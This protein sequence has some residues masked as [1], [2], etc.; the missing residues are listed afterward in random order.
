MSKIQYRVDELRVD[1]K[2]KLVISGW[3]V[4]DEDYTL[5]VIINENEIRDLEVNNSERPDV[6][7][8]IKDAPLQCGFQNI[9]PIEDVELENVK[10]QL[11]YKEEVKIIEEKHKEELFL[12]EILY[13][14]DQVH[15]IRNK[16]Y[17]S[18]WVF[19]RNENPIEIKC[20][21]IEDLEVKRVQRPDVKKCYSELQDLY[22]GFIIR[23]NLKAKKIELSFSTDNSKITYKI[24]VL[25]HKYEKLKKLM[26]LVSLTSITKALRVLFTKGPKEF[27]RKLRRKFIRADE[28][29][30]DYMDWY[31]GKAPTLN[32]LQLQTKAKF[33]YMPKVSIIVPTYNTPIK[34]LEEMIES[35]IS[36][37]YTNWEL[38]IADGSDRK[39]APKVKE[40]LEAYKE[41]DSRIK[42]KYLEKNGGISENTNA[43]LE[44]ADGE[45][46]GL[47]DHDD[48]LTPDALYEVVKV[49]NEKEDVDFIYSDEDKIEADTGR[50]YDPHFKQDWAPD[51]FRSYNYICHFTVIKKAL[52]EKVGYFRK[53]F[54]GSQDYDLFLRL[55]EKANRIYH[56]SK[57]LYHWRA[58]PNSTAQKLE[59]KSYVVDA[60]I[61]ALEEHLKRIGLEG[62][63]ESGLQEGVYNI[64]Y[65]IKDNPKISIIIPNKDHKE[66]LKLCIDTILQK[67][68]YNNYEIIVVENNS[69]TKKIRKYYQEIQKQDNIQVVTWNEGFNYSKINNF[70]AEYATGEYLILLNND[71]EI[72]TPNWMEEML[73]HCQR[74]D[75]GIVGA[76]LYYP[77]NTMQHAGVII[78]IG[79]VA[80]H[81]H[82]YFDRDDPG[83]FSRLKIVQNL[84]A[85]TAACLMVRKDVFDAVDG[86]D[87]G[88]EVAFN[89][90][91]FCLRV[92]QLGKKVIFTPYVEC[93]HY[94]SKSRGLED[95]PEKQERFQNEI[96]RFKERWGECMRDPYYNE[97][98][99]LTSENFALKNN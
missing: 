2:N 19:S 82:K 32:D 93:Y 95:S 80:G 5:K 66:D 68:T 62:T 4:Y 74:E 15:I 8:A 49:I 47:F 55:T 43:A 34:F 40:C 33:K 94:E 1:G 64:K 39:K 99:T 29:T 7:D 63:A 86:L 81:S 91:D 30:I 3:V 44:M 13:S 14:I 96:N 31:K 9:V 16:I 38:C 87:V 27:Y 46:I 54:D 58:H 23:G 61:R 17:M 22:I 36:Q 12:D 24:N 78:G 57:I 10:I 76:K 25:A 90:V 26:T 35:V 20:E 37:S 42:V 98:L 92:R 48:L 70:G 71:I 75:V 18:G 50:L 28:I 52:L 88:F 69:E 45:F 72:I 84:S 56:I 53:E 83:Y 6:K 59:A 21:D 97:N 77:D 79:G 41:K 73:M 67:S 11:A 85:V 51:T 89:D 65:L 60:G